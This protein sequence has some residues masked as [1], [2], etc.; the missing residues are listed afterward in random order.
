MGNTPKA[1]NIQ[2]WITED[3]SQFNE[4]F[5]KNYDEKSKV[6]YIVEVDVQYPKKLNELHS[7]LPFLPERKKLR[8]VKKLVTSLEDKR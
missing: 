8:K 5:I 3:I 1:S 2:F 4:V 7:D 6:G